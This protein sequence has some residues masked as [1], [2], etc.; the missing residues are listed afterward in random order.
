MHHRV[1][2]LGAAMAVGAAV[3]TL[4]AP[5]ATAAGADVERCLSD[6]ASKPHPNREV[7]RTDNTVAITE[8]LPAGSYRSAKC[9][10]S[11]NLISSVTA[12]PHRLPDGTIAWLPHK[13]AT[14]PPD[15]VTEIVADRGDLRLYDGDWRAAVAE[16]RLQVP[17]PAS[18]SRVSA[19]AIPVSHDEAGIKAEAKRMAADPTRGKP[20]FKIGKQG[21]P[22]GSG[23]VAMMSDPRCSQGVYQYSYQYKNSAT[24]WINLAP[25]S[26]QFH[27]TFFQNIAEGFNTWQYTYNVCGFSPVNGVT[28]ATAGGTQTAAATANG[29][30]GNNDGVEVVDA[31]SLTAGTCAGAVGCAYRYPDL[32]HDIRINSA[33]PYCVGW[34][35]GFYDIWSLIAHEAGHVYGFNHTS[36]AG[37]VMYPYISTN[38]ASWRYLW[39]GDYHGLFDVY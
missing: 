10:A 27:P 19:P 3:I 31:G 39:H 11:G 32:K 7:R 23:A 14:Q 5:S 37:M 8:Y 34:C 1:R 22:A 35:P 16:A 21:P 24:H 15:G 6:V 36:S 17:P 4:Q 12:E 2:A 20:R 33:Y 38:D 30:S 28:A 26:V 18:P 29:G 25:I 9:D 13:K